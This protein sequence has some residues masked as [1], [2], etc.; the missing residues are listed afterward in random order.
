VFI[1]LLLIRLIRTSVFRRGG[2]SSAE[3]VSRRGKALAAASIAV[4]LA[5]ITAGRLTA[6]VDSWK[7]FVS[8]FV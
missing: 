3:D 1:G 5:A 4:W 8:L 7:K 2:D 6:Y